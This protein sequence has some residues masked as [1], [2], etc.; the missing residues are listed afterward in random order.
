MAPKKKKPNRIY[1]VVGGVAVAMVVGL[2]FAVNFLLHND[3]GGPKQ[4]MQV[5]T[6]V[7]PPPPPP[8]VVEKP[9]EPIKQEEKIDTP[10]DM[11]AEKPEE[12][13]PERPPQNLGLDTNA[14]LGSDAFGLQAKR[15]GSNLIGGTGG[16]NAGSL[17]GWYAGVVSRD[18]Q[19]TAND[20]IQK[21]GGI[22]PGKWEK[23]TFEVMV[24]VYGKVTK[25]SIIK[26]SGSEKIDGAVRK[27]LDEAHGFEAP[28]PGMPKVMRFA[29]S[30][31]G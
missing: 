30:L 15:G 13:T 9:P 1:L 3:S 6:L 5:V 21:E 28:P 29:V 24:D 17:Y 27:A 18:L 22:P 31:Q 4:Q 16:K 12:A 11:P 19:K 2:V 26:S 25:Y 23:V 14:G 20:I 8:K 7:T 10:K